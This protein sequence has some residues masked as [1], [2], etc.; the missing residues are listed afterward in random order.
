M[1]S[2]KG[3][4]GEA[5]TFLKLAETTWSEMRATQDF[6]GQDD[7]GWDKKLP[8]NQNLEFSFSSVD[9]DLVSRSAGLSEPGHQCQLDCKSESVSPFSREGSLHPALSISAYFA[10]QG[11]D[12]EHER[13]C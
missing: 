3:F 4:G 7:D 10:E 12:R 2:V 9:P 6:F 1:Y 5:D 8:C 11:S 13:S